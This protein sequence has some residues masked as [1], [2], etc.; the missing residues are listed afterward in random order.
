MSRDRL[1]ETFSLHTVEIPHTVGEFLA[2]RRAE[3]EAQTSR[4]NWKYR[5]DAEE[6]FSNDVADFRSALKKP[7]WGQLT[8]AE[9]GKVVDA[10]LHLH[11]SAK[12]LGLDDLWQRLFEESPFPTDQVAQRLY[13][14]AAAG[15]RQALLE[16]ILALETAPPDFRQETV[17]LVLWRTWRFF[18]GGTPLP[19]SNGKGQ[20]V[21]PDGLSHATEKKRQRMRLKDANDRALA[22]VEARQLSVDSSVR[23]WAKTIGCSEG[24]VCKLPLW[25]EIMKRTGRGRKEQGTSPK[26]ISLTN[27]LEATLIPE[28][29]ELRRL[30]AEQEA[31]KE[32][33]PFEPGFSVR[34]Y[35]HV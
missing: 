25:Q 8:D 27:K 12:Q 6:R 35:K 9:A 32:P 22:L 3:L 2:N 26:A 17:D 14:L 19:S 30:I 28:K 24:S 11:E 33:S 21:Q 29:D 10:F 31:D 18:F 23:E 7:T 34:E 4:N 1:S 13:H 20:A 16:Q 5:R 15:A